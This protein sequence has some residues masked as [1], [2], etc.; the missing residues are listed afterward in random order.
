MYD[1]G[2]P[3]TGPPKKPWE[4]RYVLLTNTTP[5][6]TQPIALYLLERI[7]SSGKVWLVCR[8]ALDPE[9]ETEQRFQLPGMTEDDEFICFERVDFSTLQPNA[10]YPLGQPGPMAGAIMFDFLVTG[11]ENRYTRTNLLAICPTELRAA[12][13]FE[14]SPGSQHGDG[15]RARPVKGA[16]PSGSDGGGSCAGLEARLDDIF[17]AITAQNKRIS[18]LEDRPL[19]TGQQPMASLAATKTVTGTFDDDN[20][21][22]L[23]VA[24]RQLIAELKKARPADNPVAP[25]KTAIP[26]SSDEPA[27]PVSAMLLRATRALEQVAGRNTA[28]GGQT[29]QTAGPKF[30]LTGAQGRVQ[31]DALNQAFNDDPAAVVREFEKAVASLAALDSNEKLTGHIIQ[32]TWRNS[33]PAKEHAQIVRTSEAV[34]DAYLALRNGNV[35]RGMA[36][37]ALLLAAMEQSVLDEGK[38]NLRAAT[39]LGMPPAPVHNYRAATAEQKPSGNNKLGPLAQFCSADRS[40]TALAVYRDMNPSTTQ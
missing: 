34:L 18:A 25:E 11:E 31:Q 3:Q 14:M 33:V 9:Q 26:E 39:L 4:L 6:W 28:L 27:L 20:L 22:E 12:A 7:G 40:T 23:S 17:D 2:P 1:V 13:R 10:E 24:D 36:R 32:E 38:W 16:L 29:S 30:K 37:L 19:A 15:S 35:A 8:P 21:A 5:R